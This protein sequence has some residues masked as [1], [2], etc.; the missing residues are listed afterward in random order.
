MT[1]AVEAG[2]AA[3]S[4]L[5]RVRT[6]LIV[7]LVIL[8]PFFSGS[9]QYLGTALSELLLLALA[10]VALADYWLGGRRSF[11]VSRFEVLGILVFAAAVLSSFAAP[12][13]I[14]A[15]HA[16]GGLLLL[17]LGY[18]A[19]RSAAG[20]RDNY[21]PV[22]AGALLASGA[23][24][25]LFAIHQYLFTGWYREA[26]PGYFAEYL[27]PN[28]RD[29]VLRAA[30]G[31]IDPNNL[32][33]F[34]NLSLAL[35]IALLLFSALRWPLKVG[36]SAVGLLYVVGIA[37]TGSKAGM[38]VALLIVAGLLG[39]KDKR[40]LVVV[41]LVLVVLI[42]VPNPMRDQYIRALTVDPY[43]TTRIGIW[44][45]SLEMALDNPLI[46]VGPDN[47][48]YVAH[49]SQPETD[50]FL[51]HYSHVPT[52]A[53]NSYLHAF[54]ELGLV[55]L[56]PLLLMVAAAILAFRAAASSL[57]GRDKI[58]TADFIRLGIAAGISGLL[59]H[60]LV[61]N[62]MHNRCL[63][64]VSLFLF[65]ALAAKF[66]GEDA[67]LPGFFR[68]R[69]SIDLALSHRAV[70][71]I[72]ILILLAGFA[73]AQIV[74]PLNY[75]SRM[76]EIGPRMSSAISDYG[77][78]PA[79]LDPSRRN[80]ARQRLV[81]ELRNIVT[82]LEELK[83]WYPS[84]SALLLYLGSAYKEI[85]R[86]DGDIY[87]FSQALLNFK[88]AEASLPGRGVETFQQVD[89]YFDL[90]RKGYPKTEDILETLDRLAYRAIEQWPQRAAFYL[91]AATVEKEK[92]PAGLRKARG[93]LDRA[94]EL[95]PNYLAALNEL[96]LVAEAMGDDSLRDGAAGMYREALARIAKG[97]APEADDGYAWQIIA[98]PPGR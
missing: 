55:G 98:I 24:Q 42:A 7:A 94:I 48:R 49:R 14:A 75:E 95:E 39:L 78:I 60:S 28:I 33:A 61:H 9:T 56:L 35:V 77:S 96:G 91:L 37:L 46:G 73:V 19:A 92:G 17:G 89:T 25:S 50:Q 62:I 53:H 31:F 36:L 74:R 79:S 29:G 81:V 69:Y 13:G 38:A 27:S 1:A 93:L 43:F 44:G 82:E 20:E 18:R 34:L 52:K 15:W 63:L 11:L 68:R 10:C 90:V 72:S 23:I 57:G 40:L 88:A 3:T 6:G 41:A 21:L 5:G 59:V 84:N 8:T 54:A 4:A 2:H 76:R 97:P 58:A 64:A 12:Y 26:L 47:F 87:A 67:R 32:A 86:A 80:F 70:A 85:L 30:A 51:V 65:A 66:G 45:S 16:V 22:V 83:R 71:V